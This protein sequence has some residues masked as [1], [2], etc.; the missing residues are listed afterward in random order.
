MSSQPEAD[1]DLALIDLIV[2]YCAADGAVFTDLIVEEDKHIR[3]KQPAGLVPISEFLVERPDIE[4]VLA[5]IDPEWK[6]KIYQGAISK[7]VLLK[8]QRVRINGYSFNSRDR[9]GLAVRRIPSEPISIDK[10]GL[11]ISAVGLGKESRGLVLF[12]GS[13]GSGKSM[14]IASFVDAINRHRNSHIIT[15]EDPIEFLL[16]EKKST[17][18]S[19]E[20][21]RDVESFSR[22]VKDA[23]REIPD[24]LVI[25][26][27][28]D[29]ATMETALYASESGCLVFAS[30]HANTSEGALSKIINFFP[31]EAKAR[32]QG[33]ATSLLGVVSQ[34]LLPSK[35]G[36][37][38]QLVSEVLINTPEIQKCIMEMNWNGIRDLLHGQSP[39]KQ[40]PEGCIP[41]NDNLVRLVSQGHIDQAVARR[42]AIHSSDYAARLDRA[43]KSSR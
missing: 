6:S 14:S 8:G 13:T 43:L 1:G 7:A 19:K 26:E 9:I 23:M 12:I 39:T 28:R 4:M 30:M 5:D 20:V 2:R 27:I 38:F 10:L 41:L 18:T 29:K 37:Q 25:G 32:A 33:L 15:I 21:G 24:V 35:S 17:I 11:P 22:G 34:M 40:A 16:T 3:Q 36:D 42:V 31:D